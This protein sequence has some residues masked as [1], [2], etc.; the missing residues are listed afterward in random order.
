MTES[1][2]L[3]RTLVLFIVA[4]LV[5]PTVA[6]HGANTFSFIMRSEVVQ[7]NSAQ[8]LQNDT[9]VFYN[10]A[11]Y[12]RSVLLDADGD[13]MEEFACIAGP[14]NSLNTSDEC[15]LWLDPTNWSAGNYE[16]RIISNGTLWNTIPISI[17]LDNH[18][19]VLP[20]DGFVFEP[21]QQEAQK[22]GLERFFL[23][24]A[25]ILAGA[26]ALVRISRNKSGD[27]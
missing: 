22:E 12:N 7:P 23:S 1:R 16:I 5:M 20:P 11:D 14:S 13:G 15:Y 9:L 27:E 26:A 2:L 24:A 8:V 19:E 25:I 17:Q 3:S 6:A 4:T 18:T 21:E 10:T